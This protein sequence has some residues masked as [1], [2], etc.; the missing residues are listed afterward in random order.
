MATTQL[1]ERFDQVSLGN[2]VKLEELLITGNKNMVV[3]LYPELDLQALQIQLA[4]F[5]ANNTYTSCKEAVQILR[6]MP[7][8]VRGLFS[9]VE[10]LVRLLLVVPVSSCEAERSFSALRRL[11]NWPR[12]TMTQLRLNSTA[13][14]HI[15]RDT[16]KALDK[17]EIATAFIGTSERRVH[18]FGQF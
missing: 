2:L 1:H 14:C 11:K 10:T 9:Q 13:V 3:S 12:T 5:K 8:E 18:V 4:M 16:L 6:G 15:H 17:R 7:P